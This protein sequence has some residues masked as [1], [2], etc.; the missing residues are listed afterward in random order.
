M[1]PQGGGSRRLWPGVNPHSGK[2][3]PWKQRAVPFSGSS[4]PIAAPSLIPSIMA[5]P[6]AAKETQPAEQLPHGWEN[7]RTIKVET[8]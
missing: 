4:L 6:N 8:P 1:S 2:G 3:F 5:T 7:H